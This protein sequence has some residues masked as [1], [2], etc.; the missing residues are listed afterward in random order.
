MLNQ[1]EWESEGCACAN[2][3][4]LSRRFLQLFP[5]ASRPCYSV[6]T[7]AEPGGVFL[8]VLLV[9]DWS[10][11]RASIPL[12]WA[13]HPRGLTLT[14]GVGSLVAW[15]GASTSCSKAGRW[16][17]LYYPACRCAKWVLSIFG[18]LSTSSCL[19]F[20]CFRYIQDIVAGLFISFKVVSWGLWLEPYT[21]LPDGPT[22]ASLHSLPPSI[23]VYCGPLL[24]W[25]LCP[26]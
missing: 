10:A 19:F 18:W 23:H 8:W 1:L 7:S 12:S 9:C 24:S 11:C 6:I 22:V 14:A 4:S 2:S 17:T 25:L 20:L 21:E 26:C 3:L 15:G 16:F 13:Y 5:V